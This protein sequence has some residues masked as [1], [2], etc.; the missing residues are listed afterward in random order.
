MILQSQ[1]EDE[2]FTM[3]VLSQIA[4]FAPVDVSL[5]MYE[6]VYYP[7]RAEQTSATGDEVT[8]T[9]VVVDIDRTAGT[10]VVTLRSPLQVE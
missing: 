10:P 4:T 6:R 8:R 1:E 7:L 5:G 9:G 2:Q 3:C